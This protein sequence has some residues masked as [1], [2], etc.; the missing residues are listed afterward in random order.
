MKSNNVTASA[1]EQ[2]LESYFQNQ[3]SADMKDYDD[4]YEQNQDSDEISK[5][6]EWE[7][8]TNS[9]HDAGVLTRDAGLVVKIN[10]QEFQITIV[11]SK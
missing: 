3:A 10:G 6:E 11:K 7:I 2:I 8:D 4:C 5:S 1:I 9:F